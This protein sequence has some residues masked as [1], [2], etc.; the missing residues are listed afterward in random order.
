MK[1]PGASRFLKRAGGPDA[2][3]PRGQEQAHRSPK[4]RNRGD[5]PTTDAGSGRNN[6]NE[7]D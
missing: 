3:G 6:N 1:L 4:M 7:D 5:Y 2:K